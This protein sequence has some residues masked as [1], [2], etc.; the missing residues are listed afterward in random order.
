MKKSIFL[1]WVLSLLLISVN[2]CAWAEQVET[3]SEQSTFTL[4]I[5]DYLINLRAEQVSLKEILADLEKKTGIKVNIFDGE[6]F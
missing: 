2:L 1:F 4:E 6:G 5:K 3:K